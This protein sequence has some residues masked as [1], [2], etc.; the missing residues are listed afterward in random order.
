MFP[1]TGGG[2]AYVG[3]IHAVATSYT[4]FTLSLNVGTM[5]G[6]IIDVYGYAKA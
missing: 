4:D 6:G 5:T 1:Q 3:G 2:S